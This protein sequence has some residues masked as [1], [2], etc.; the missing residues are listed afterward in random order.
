MQYVLT[1]YTKRLEPY[2]WWEG[3]FTEQELDW[4]Q[5]KA[6]NAEQAG[7]VGGGNG[8][9]VNA[10]VR[11]S[12]VSWLG[13]NADTKWIFERLAFVVSTLNAQHFNFDL[14]GFGEALQLT[15]YDQSENG[16]YGWHQDCGDSVCRKLSVVVQL[17]D[18]LEYDGGNL[19][20]MFSSDPINIEKRRGLIAVF[21]SF[22]LHQVTPVTRGSRQSLV[23]WASGPTFR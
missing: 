10:N 21:P 6:K 14:T 11:R 22:M 19:Q 3:A 23:T 9:T 13:N 4:L 5:E 1:P 2:A 20:I 18:P 12:Q 16:M 17:A 15:N 7:Q 8:G